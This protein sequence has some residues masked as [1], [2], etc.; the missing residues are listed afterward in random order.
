M[1]NCLYNILKENNLACARIFVALTSRGIHTVID[2]LER[3]ED[4]LKD[5]HDKRVVHGQSSK[6][7]QDRVD[8]FARFHLIFPVEH[9]KLTQ[10]LKTLR[11][12]KK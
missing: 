11:D 7:T 5:M 4:A 3:G 6:S 1:D 8:G 12:T 2:F 10:V 9:S